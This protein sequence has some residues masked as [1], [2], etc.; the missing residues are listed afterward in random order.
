MSAKATVW[1]QRVS[2]EFLTAE[3][4]YILETYNQSGDESMSIARARVSQGVSTAWHALDGTVE[5]YI[6]AEGEGRVEVG[7]FPPS[8][9][10]PGDVVIIPAGVRQR[11]T[12]T[13]NC[14]LI[15]YCV[16]TPRFQ[17]AAYRDFRNC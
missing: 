15:F 1:K 10:A 16:C 2:R 5:R 12:N 13:G 4:C 6:I 11:I 14:D 3:G 9:V 7:D 17:T 8:D